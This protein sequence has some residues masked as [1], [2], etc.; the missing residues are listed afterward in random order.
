MNVVC[1]C[2]GYFI[3]FEMDN[4]ELKS[5]QAHHRRYSHL[6]GQEIKKAVEWFIFPQR[7]HANKKQKTSH[8]N[9]KSTYVD[10]ETGRVS[11]PTSFGQVDTVASNS[12]GLRT[13]AAANKKKKRKVKKLL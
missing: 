7:R 13:A 12:H 8:R 5:V 2:K 3:L 10:F 4:I 6:D 9:K 11:F 1:N